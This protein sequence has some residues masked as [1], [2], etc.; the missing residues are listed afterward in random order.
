MRSIIISA[1]AALAGGLAVRS[2]EAA[3][4]TNA[5][6]VIPVTG[7]V[8]IINEINTYRQKAKLPLLSWN[9]QLAIN[10]WN[11]GVNNTLTH[12]GMHPHHI[13]FPGSSAQVIAE[14]FDD[15]GVCSY[16][17]QPFT[18]F[19]FSLL[20]WLCELPTDPAIQPW[21]CS[22]AATISHQSSSG[23]LGHWEIFHAAAYHNI[24]CAFVPWS[25]GCVNFS[26]GPWN[27]Y[28]VCDFS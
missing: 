20:A 3:T 15:S 25:Y 4:N 12:A 11:T 2:S 8:P 13:L 6:S 28:W 21:S 7:G 27:G 1:F 16:N 24:G 19:L 9:Q 14:G 18:P 22:V 10:S 5:A 17:I 26:Y 23:E